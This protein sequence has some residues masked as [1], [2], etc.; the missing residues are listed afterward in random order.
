MIFL[1]VNNNKN[2]NN[3]KKKLNKKIKK[4]KFNIKYLKEIKKLQKTIPNWNNL[5][6]KKLNNENRL[7]QWIR[8]RI[9]GNSLIEKYSWA[10]P[11][12]NT[13]N[14]IKEFSPLIEL[15][16][17]NGYWARYLFYLYYLFYN[18]K[19]KL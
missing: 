16:A 18:L 13:L 19:F 7:E 2:K 4:L 5:F 10:I 11:D 1:N 6:S 3:N 17:G 8:L 15:G 9:F 12:N 14:I